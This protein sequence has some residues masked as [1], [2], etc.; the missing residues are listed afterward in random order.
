MPGMIANKVFYKMV[1]VSIITLSILN[2]CENRN[3]QDSE[4]ELKI[5]FINDNHAQIDNFSKIKYII[6]EAEEEG[7][8]IL[9]SSGDMFSGNPLVD[10]YEKKGI[11]TAVD[12][13][14]APDDVYK[15]LKKVVS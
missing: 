8:V 6:D 1:I 12:A 14:P 11:L 7:K 4:T 13:S 3:K 5:F 2:S 10:F 15:E 9:V